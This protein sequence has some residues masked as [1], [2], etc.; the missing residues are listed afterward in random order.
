MTRVASQL[1]QTNSFTAGDAIAARKRFSIFQLSCVAR[2]IARRVLVQEAGFYRLPTRIVTTQRIC[3]QV[4]DCWKFCGGGHRRTI[5]AICFPRLLFASITSLQQIPLLRSAHRRRQGFPERGLPQGLS[6]AEHARA[7][8]HRAR[9]RTVAPV[10]RRWPHS[11][12]SWTGRSDCGFGISVGEFKDGGLSLLLGPKQ[13][14][15]DVH[16]SAALRGRADIR[17]IARTIRVY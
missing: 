6:R 17:E 12:G 9:C 16:F 5:S 8:H 4:D 11:F 2:R 15:S 7:Q 10:S 14:I 3:E 1:R 13:P